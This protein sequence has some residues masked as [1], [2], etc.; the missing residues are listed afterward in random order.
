MEIN[1]EKIIGVSPQFC[2]HF[3]DENRVL[4]LSEQRS[5]RL[6]GRLYVALLPYLN[7]KLTGLDVIKIFEE[8]VPFDRMKSVLQNMLSK[9][10]ISYL[11]ANA[12]IERQAMLV[13]LG[14]APEISERRL[15]TCPIAVVPAS[16]DESV[17]QATKSLLRVLSQSGFSVVDQSEAEIDIFVVED[18]L[19]SDLAEINHQMRKAGRSWLPFKAGGSIPLLGPLFR[20]DGERCWSCLR[21]HMSEHRPG[22]NLIE[23]QTDKIRPA[24]AYTAASIDLAVGF[25]AMELMREIASDTQQILESH[26]LSLDLSQRAFEQHLIRIMPH[27]EVCGSTEDPQTVL[28]RGC[29]PLV[30]N[31]HS[32]LSNPDGGWRTLKPEQVVNKLSRYVSPITGIISAVEDRSLA[33]GLPVFTARQTNPVKVGPRQN[34]LIGRPSGAAGKG[35]SEVQAKASCLA[36]A[37]ERYQCGFTGHEPRMRA[38]WEAVR[39]T[40]PHPYTYL[41]Y[42]E[43]Q[44][45]TREEWNDKNDAFNW[46]GE[47]FDESRS[48]EWTPAWSLTRNV[49]RWLPTRACYFSY[50]DYSAAEGDENKFCRADSNGCASGSTIEEA[51]IQGF[52]ELIER[53]ACGIWWYNRVRRPEFDITEL[54]DPFVKRSLEY[55]RDRNF[56]LSVLDLTNDLGLPV[57]IAVAHNKADGKSIHFGLGSHFDA[58]IAVSR[59][60]AELNQMFTL[61]GADIADQAKNEISDKESS[62]ILDWLKNHSVETDPYCLSEGLVS[63]RQYERPK[64]NDLKQAVDRCVRAVSDRDYDMI[65]LNL[66]RQEIEFATARVVVPDLRHFWARFREGRL[67]QAPVDLGWLSQ[68]LLETELNPIPFFL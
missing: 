14:L 31:S 6:N 43:Q 27:C 61:E 40:A 37:M 59:A 66:S 50:V 19:R 58:E 16:Q 46:V 67:Y 3:T 29:Q 11:D 63:V 55:C 57:A 51:I 38:T 5:F 34:R 23:T 22:D 1:L 28:D 25:A 47:R 15:R 45:D 26:V 33:S 64:I 2:T 42:S 17:L 54:D 44:Y 4:L 68:S 12:P 39:D 60:L 20:P 24:R 56:Q 21:S 49:P 13:E 41:N 18:Y 7:G 48:I 62:P 9:N 35:M 30:L 8:R 10:Y 53:D 32:V 65:V 52:F 36:E